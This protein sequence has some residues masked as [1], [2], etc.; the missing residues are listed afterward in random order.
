MTKSGLPKSV[1]KFIRLEKARIRGQFWDIKKQEEMIK[2]LYM[3]FLHKP[4]TEGVSSVKETKKTEVKVVKS[5][6]TK[7]AKKVKP[8][9]NEKKHNKT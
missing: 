7:F 3:N 4:A 2:E 1:R 9:E 5:K 8:R 6:Q